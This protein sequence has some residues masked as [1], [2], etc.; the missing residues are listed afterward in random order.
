MIKLLDLIG[1]IKIARTKEIHIE[2]DQES[3]IATLRFYKIHD[4]GGFLRGLL[5]KTFKNS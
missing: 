1:V 2:N 5:F 4:P 3:G